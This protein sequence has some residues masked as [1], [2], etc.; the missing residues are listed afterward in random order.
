MSDPSGPADRDL[1]RFRES[2]PSHLE[3]LEKARAELDRDPVEAAAALRR[4]ARF[5]SEEADRLQ[6]NS[7]RR[8]AGELIEAAAFDLAVHV[9]ALEVALTA[10]LP[11]QETHLHILIVEDESTSAL[12]V[13][14]V[15]EGDDREV[16]VVGTAKAARRALERDLFDLVV[17]DLI[18][19]DAD[20]RHLLMEL[21]REVDASRTSV[22]VVTAK[23]TAT[24]RAECFA[25]GARAFLEKPLDPEELGR[26]TTDLLTK[27][28]GREVR[29]GTD[30]RAS[31]PR[32]GSRS[33]S[34]HSGGSR[35]EGPPR[36]G[37]HR[38]GSERTGVG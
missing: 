36:T 10:L 8:P 38:D 30:F 23:G 18:L 2:V 33:I 15:L 6:L 17:L 37:A 3:L 7:L 20:G 24:T 1:E 35:G 28:G 21:S 25:Y 29:V 13:R 31:G 34:A 16:R 27:G 26:V 9:E 5:V 14:R 12:L 19:P 22:I 11:E 32:A 4:F